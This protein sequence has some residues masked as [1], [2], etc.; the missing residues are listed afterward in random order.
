M[1]ADVF[2]DSGGQAD[3]PHSLTKLLFWSVGLDLL[4][5]LPV[6]L[7]G[8][9]GVLASRD[10]GASPALGGLMVSAYFFAGAACAL[11]TGALVDRMG[12]R[13]AAALGL[14][15]LVG[16]LVAPALRGSSVTLVISA[17]VAG[18]GAAL[19]QPAT[20]ALISHTV[21]SRRRALAIN[22]K[23][24]A[25]P[26]ALLVAG[27]SIPV[28]AQ[29]VGWRTTF[30][31]AALGPCIALCFIW[32]VSDARASAGRT[33]ALQEPDG[34]VSQR[35]LWVVGMSVFLGAMVPGTLIAFM[36]PALVDAG[37]SPVTA[38]VV[39]AVLSVLTV[40]GRVVVGL[41]A[42]LRLLSSFRAVAVLMLLGGGGAA[43]MLWPHP[44]ALL[45]GGTLAFSMGFAWMG[46]A[47]ALAV[48]MFP[49]RPGAASA[50]IQSGGMGGSAA[51]PLLGVSAAGQFGLSAAWLFAAVTSVCGA[52]LMFL[53]APRVQQ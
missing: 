43:S 16:G 19:V 21:V 46:Q 47:F 22:V 50:I 32:T 11:F 6:G 15:M 20:S 7:A 23:M 8:A 31:A 27:L 13:L 45:L 38:G 14:L 39:L 18:A 26:G 52:L 42:H 53:R 28:L 25:A 33:A 34:P 10:I 29:F 12:W 36:V 30:L 44:A 2:G 4:A 40:L 41:C 35:S 5:V 49:S 17:M 37:Y 24:A 51:G 9:L 3:V 1:T 48:K